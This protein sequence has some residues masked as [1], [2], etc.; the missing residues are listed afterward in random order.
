MNIKKLLALI[1]AALLIITCFVS[2]SD[3][4]S[5][6]SNTNSDEITQDE[7]S[8]EDSDA[9][10][11]EDF[12]ESD[13]DIFYEEEADGAEIEKVKTDLS[14][15]YGTWVSTSA[16]AE[17]FYGNIEITVNEDG[18]WSGNI[19]GEDLNGKWTDK[20]DYLRLESDL[21]SFDLAYSDTGKLIMIEEDADEDG[22]D[23]DIN[24][25]LTKK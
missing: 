13:N 25:V 17:Y 19:T 1:L 20:G 23:S 16:Q 3:S 14:E 24:V 10:S 15:F 6:N 8:D 7:D 9:D 2:C 5:A 4:G 18:T 12:L 11:E 22:D 21:F